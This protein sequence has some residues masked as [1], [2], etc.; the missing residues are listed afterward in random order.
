M[1]TKTKII[2]S[3]SSD[4]RNKFRSY[5]VLINEV[6]AGSVKNG[7]A[8]E[9]SVQPGNNSIQCSMGW[10]K[11]E[12]FSVDV[13]EGETVYL[14]VRSGMKYFWPLYIALLAGLFMVFYFQRRADAPV[15][16][17]P[18]GLALIIPGFLYNLYYTTLGRKR[19]FVI[20]KD[21][22]NIFA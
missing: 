20:G 1:D 4:W 8:E 10:Y 12:S 6:E 15:W 5:K 7:S 2:L 16:A 13:K 9:Y 3:R 17:T 14:R 21:T 11:S 18:L 22:K 19:Y